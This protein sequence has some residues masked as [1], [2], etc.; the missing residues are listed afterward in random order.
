[1]A[2]ASGSRRGHRERDAP[3]TRLGGLRRGGSLRLPKW[4]AGAGRSRHATGRLASWRKPPAPEEGSGSGTLPPRD[5]SAC[6]VAGASGSRS[7]QRERDAPATRPVGLRRGGSLR[8][9]K[10]E[11]EAGRSRHEP[12][13]LAPW[14]EPPAP[15]EGSGSGTLPPRDR[16]ACVVAGASG[17]RR[18]QRERDA[19]ATRPVGLRRSASWRWPAIPA[20]MD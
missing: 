2:G 12:R 7:G 4:V 10:W 16:S 13:R 15:E 5:R 1:V 20:K 19:P 18:G 14:R 6:A 8:L 3:A 9:P 11:A 17:S